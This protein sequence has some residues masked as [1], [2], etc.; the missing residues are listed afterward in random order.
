[1]KKTYIIISAIAAL[2][3]TSA[4]NLK[5]DFPPM[6]GEDVITLDLLCAEPGVKSDG[7]GKEN[8]INTV[9]YFFYTD[10][11]KAPVYVKWDTNPA[12]KI[13]GSTY[14]ISLTAGQ[15][16]VPTRSELFQDGKFEIYAIF[17]AQDS[18]PAAKLETVKQTAVDQTFAYFK[19]ADPNKGWNVTPDEDPEN[20]VKEFIMTGQKT[21]NKASGGSYANVEAEKTVDMKR[22]AA[23][24]EVNL[25]V[26]KEKAL[27]GTTWNPMLG[28]ANVRLYMCNFVQNSLLG[29]ADASPILPTSYTQADYRVY[30]L[31]TDDLEPA[32]TGYYE[33]PCQ[34]TFYTYPIEWEAGAANEPYFKL[35][36]PWAEKDGTVPNKEL[37]YKIMFPP[38][39]TSLEANKHYIL[40]VTVDLLGNEGE[41]TVTIKGYNAQVVGWSENGKVNSSVAAATFLSVERDSTEYYTENSGISFV[42]SEM[43][44]LEITNVYQKN[45]KTGNNEYVVKNGATTSE[46]T[47]LGTPEL[48]KDASNRV[49]GLS[50]TKNG[51]TTKWI[52][53]S[54]DNSYL[55]VGHQLDAD[56]TSEHMD[57]TPWV[58]EITM[59]LVGVN[60]ASYNRKVV[61]EQYPNVYIVADPNSNINPSTGEGNSTALGLFING[62]G[63]RNSQTTT[64]SWHKGDYQNWNGGTKNTYNL[65]NANGLAGN[66][67]NRNPNMYIITIS[68]SNKYSIGDPRTSSVQMPEFR[69][70]DVTRSGRYPNYN[71]QY[72]EWE[73]HW[74]E[75]PALGESSDRQLSYYHPASSE[76]TADMIAP[77]IR[78][79]SS[80]GVCSVG[81]NGQPGRTKEEAILRCATYQEDGIPAGRWRL[82]TMAEVEFISTLSSLGRIPYLFGS[83]SD[84]GQTPNDDPSPYWTANGVVIVNNGNA[85][86]TVK[87]SV[88]R[89][90]DATDD[91]YENKSVRCVYDE[92]F[93]GDATES[94][95][96][97]KGTFTWGDRNY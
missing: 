90:E 1:M 51:T 33:I 41:P 91:D 70:R 23:K 15:D 18:I 84:N 48:V 28:A 58:Y 27:D 24:V 60:D 64:T 81:N 22:I 30:A 54:N 69:S 59:K 80:Y 53:L 5:T 21:I 82:P 10:T 78:I 45:L 13:S 12:A 2:A 89:D 65:G 9:E 85:S 68:V 96:V 6:A 95:P 73:N 37:Y 4:C 25:K 87:P 19:E 14:T 8:A 86:G 20:R 71:Y 72:G 79:A 56:L 31:D 16:G 52:E 38:S 11:T 36:I 67:G 75:A 44:Y 83:S 47:D 35:I 34:Q 49:I 77:M 63:N 74:A 46:R 32:A 42:A 93:W 92:W 50:L 3:L 17:N 57:V 61:F 88:T 39:I 26:L 97:D 7:V 66:A 55:E 43:V 94:R 29:A 62:L 40:D 76:N